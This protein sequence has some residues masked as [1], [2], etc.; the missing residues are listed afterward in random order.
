MKENPHGGDIYSGRYDYDFSVNVNPFGPPESVRQ[1]VRES[2]EYLTNYPDSSCQALRKAL[3]EK[4]AVRP[5][6]LI[7]GNGAAELIFA[8]V[9]AVRP[10]KALLAASLCERAHLYVWDEP[11]NYID[12]YSR[13]QLENLILQF[14]PTLIFVEHDRAFRE[15]VATKIIDI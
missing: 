3:S 6:H 1:A 2:V 9:Q 5:D 13:I 7:F 10:K 11:L 8:L 12:I 14:A 15:N 4:L